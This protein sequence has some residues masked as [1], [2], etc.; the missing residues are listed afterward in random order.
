MIA[1]GH[2]GS[3]AALADH[4]FAAVAPDDV[5]RRV[6]S[7]ATPYLRTRS[8]DRHTLACVPFAQLLAD[9]HP[10]AERGVVMLAMLLHDVG[11]STVPDDKLLLSFGPN[12]KYPELRRQHE[13]EGARIARE[14]LERCGQDARVI[15]RVTTIIDG[16]DTREESRSVED[17]IVRDADKLWRYTPF[18]LEMLREWFGYSTAKQLGLL[19]SWIPSRF[20]TDEAVTMPRAM[21]ASLELEALGSL[22]PHE[23][24]PSALR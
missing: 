23:A 1:G 7:E 21:L 3:L 11:W 24:T 2:D 15:E 16:H 9:A 20:Q 8:N 17:S 10:E 18:G 12:T 14:I 13:V 4:V 6:W 5:L 19:G 22:T